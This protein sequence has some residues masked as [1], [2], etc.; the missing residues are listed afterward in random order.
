MEKKWPSTLTSY[1]F[2]QLILLA[3]A[4]TFDAACA[5]KAASGKADRKAGS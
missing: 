5:T 2:T 4:P 1:C 3:L